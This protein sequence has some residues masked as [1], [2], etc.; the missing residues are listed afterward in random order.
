MLGADSAL[1]VE[2]G[3]IV[4]TNR[5]FCIG[6]NLTFKCSI[7]VGAYEWTVIGFLGGTER[8]GRVTIGETK[9]AGEFTLSAVGVATANNDTRRSLLKVTTFQRLVGERTVTCQEIGNNF[10][11]QKATITVL[12]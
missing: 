4:T 6:A 12:G 1:V 7:A 5:E 3:G 2:N 11:T 9:T 10:N 8:N